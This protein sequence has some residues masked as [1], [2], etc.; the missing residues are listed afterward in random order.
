MKAIVLIKPQNPEY[1]ELED[2][3]LDKEDW[4]KIGVKAVG[5]CGSDMHKINSS[6][7]PSS[8]LNIHVLGHEFSGIILEKGSQVHGLDLGERVTASPLIPCGSCE[9]CKEHHSQLCDNIDSIG[10]TLPGAFSEQVLVPAKNIRKIIDSTSYEQACLTD[11][12]A[13]AVH[14]YHLAGSPI[15][16][17]VLIIGD[18]AVGLSCLQVYAEHKNIIDVIGKHHKPKIESLNGTY[19]DISQ[20]NNLQ[21]NQYDIIIETVGRAQEETIAQSIRLIKPQGRI[22]VAGVYESGYQGNIL[23]RNLFYKEATLQGSNSYGVWN[24]IDE[25]DAALQMMENGT[26]QSKELI[27]HQLPLKL[28]LQGVNLMNN[29][30][31]SKAI[32][33]IYI[34]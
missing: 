14:N 17:N 26:I 8:Y 4:V 21:N 29:K 12:I 22:I 25:F 3:I 6:N 11:V 27:T 34:P 5:L 18:G 2:L 10:R 32:K 16:K 23:F 31:E 30:N 15:R 19:I 24:G 13:V 7:E 33:V 9:P 1:K 28:F 20:I